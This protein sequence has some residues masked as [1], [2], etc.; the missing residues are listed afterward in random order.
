M[1]FDYHLAV[2][3]HGEGPTLK[4]CLESFGEHVTPLP[5]S[6]T[7]FRDGRGFSH[8]PRWRHV[9]C[10]QVDGHQVGF[11][12]ASAALW[13]QATAAARIRDLGFVFWLEHDF[14]FERD[15]DLEQL[16][17]PLAIDGNLAQ[18]AFMRDAVNHEERAA[19][20]L[21]ESRRDQYLSRGDWLAHSAYF[22]TN[23]SLMTTCFMRA[24][25]WPDFR[26][27]CEGRFGAQLLDRGYY[28]GAWGDGA[29]W[30]R[31]VGKRTGFGY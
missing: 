1:S 18:M 24:N 9:S 26:D 21:Y 4:D 19:G 23:P 27:Q 17:V 5:E 30:V 7:V 6:T 11:C 28:F 15:V 22:T 31:H 3:T 20:G 29:P 12:R 13:E 2:L 8:M 16:A 10:M 25:P 14:V